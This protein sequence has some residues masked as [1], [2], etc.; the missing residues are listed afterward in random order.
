M[1]WQRPGVT[2]WS[3]VFAGRLFEKRKQ[4]ELRRSQEWQAPRSSVWQP[5]THGDF[6]TA[7][8]SCTGL[9]GA[10][11]V[12]DPWRLPIGRTPAKNDC[13]PSRM[14]LWKL[15]CAVPA[16]Q[17]RLP[18]PRASGRG[19]AP[20]RAPAN[21]PSGQD[22][23]RAAEGRRAAG[24]EQTPARRRAGRPGQAA[25]G[26]LRWALPAAAARGAARHQGRQGGNRRG[27]P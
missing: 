2:H 13:S 24:L 19:H 17:H 27:S 3:R 5:L 23:G 21:T 4:L 26:A 15:C 8:E 7:P 18:S 22:R 1:W 9:E 14:L 25:R 16:P 10:M 6:P 11:K 12:P 20:R